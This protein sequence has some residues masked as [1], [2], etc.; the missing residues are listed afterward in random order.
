M[1]ILICGLG[2]I[3][4]RHLRH[5][6]SLG[7]DRIDAFRTGLATLSD[8]GQTAPDRVFYNIGEALA[9]KPDVVIIA[10]PT[11]L[12]VGLAKLAVEAGSH[13]LIEKPLSHSLDGV[14]ELIEI[15]NRSGRIVSVAQ[16]LRYHPVLKILRQWIHDAETLG[17]PQLFR[18]H[19]GSFLP[20]WHPWEDYRNS[21]AG[22]VELGGGCRRTHIHEL[23]YSVWMMG[24][25]TDV[26]VLESLKHPIQTEV[27]E[28]TAFV[29]RHEN[30]A[31]STVTLSLAEI[32][33]SRS[34]HAAFTRGSFS[35]DL[36][37]GEWTARNQD[38]WTQKVDPPAGFD[39]DTTYREQAMD[40]LRAVRG[41]IAAPVPLEEAQEILKVALSCEARKR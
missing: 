23:D 18:A 4:R 29:M 19:C 6:R 39:I 30:G 12:H 11:S 5:F 16:N 9:E 41:E 36:I 26:Q 25:V 27:D 14:D 17:E 2:S 21:Y 35:A 7:V 32:P 22:S 33:P 40:F 8:A 24:K 1:H 31:L 34:I 10:N 28:V 20:A 38:G 13:V 37:S 3:G 15:S